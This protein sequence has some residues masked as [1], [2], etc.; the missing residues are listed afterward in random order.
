M[1][2]IGGVSRLL[3]RISKLEHA[4]ELELKSIIG[5]LSALIR[6][7]PAAQTDFINLKGQEILLDLLG[8]VSSVN[9]K[10]A[11]FLA[12]LCE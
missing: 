6:H 2:K 12:D 3:S 8:K 5:A 9:M 11:T 10:I 7:F 4:D 1:H